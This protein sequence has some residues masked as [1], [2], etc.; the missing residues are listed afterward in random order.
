MDW[1]ASKPTNLCNRYQTSRKAL[2][3]TILDRAQQGLSEALNTITHWGTRN[4]KFIASKTA[5]C[6][7]RGTQYLPNM[8]QWPGIDSKRFFLACCGFDW[9][10][11]IEAGISVLSG[12]V[13]FSWVWEHYTKHKYDQPILLSCFGHC[14]SNF[15]HITWRSLQQGYWFGQWP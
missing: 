7:T 11:G 1:A 14:S 2:I 8:N 4:L 9:R 10:C 3:N 13:F 12:Q 15:S 5:N 6:L